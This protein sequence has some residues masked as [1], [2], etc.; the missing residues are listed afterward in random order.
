MDTIKNALNFFDEFHRGA[1]NRVAHVVGFVGLF[2]S[3]YKLD[4]KLFALFLIILEGGHVYNHLAGIKPYD[5]RPKV[6]FWRVSIFLG[7]VGAFYL[8]CGYFLK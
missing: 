3:V 8:F 5:F 7:V 4:W 1:V 2:Y 6:T